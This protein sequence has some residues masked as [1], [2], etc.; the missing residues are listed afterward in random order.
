[1]GYPDK[2]TQFFSQKKIATDTAATHYNSNSE[3]HVFNPEYLSYLKAQTEELEQLYDEFLDYYSLDDLELLQITA[4]PANCPDDYYFDQASALRVLIFFPKF[5]L[6]GKGSVAGKPFRLGPW[7]IKIC[8]EVYGWLCYGSH[9]RRFRQVWIEIAR[10]NGKTDFGGGILIYESIA[11]AVRGG[12]FYI[13]AKDEAQSKIMFDRIY[14]MLEDNPVLKTLCV[15][16][17]NA[18]WI[19][20]LRAVIRHI[21]GNPKGKHGKH[22]TV[23]AIDE[24]HEITSDELYNVMHKGGVATKNYIEWFFTTAGERKG[25]GFEKHQYMQKILDGVVDLNDSIYIQ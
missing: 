12:E 23:L 13:I 10:K 24:A 18:V 20:E 6:H 19:K 21:S 5:L 7:Q 17:K 11:L 4:I 14:E 16:N 8:W 1:M 22:T 15:L 3:I 9:D 25:W 2:I